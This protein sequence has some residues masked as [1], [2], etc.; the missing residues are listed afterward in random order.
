MTLDELFTQYME[1]NGQ[2]L[3]RPDK[4]RNN[5]RLYLSGWGTRKL[6]SIKHE[7]VD[8]L[9]KDLAKSKSNVTANIALKLLHVTFNK[10]IHSIRR[11]GPVPNE[12]LGAQHFVRSPRDS[13]R[14]R[15]AS[16]SMM[17]SGPGSRDARSVGKW[18]SIGG[19][20]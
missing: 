15:C 20:Q 18:S 12:A 16:S 5:Y 1:R 8:R 11:V 3:R 19:R 7:E 4:A 2:H 14:R 10:A 9:H 17:R 6:S 13:I